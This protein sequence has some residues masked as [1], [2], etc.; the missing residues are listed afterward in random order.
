[1]SAGREVEVIIRD[2][3][4]GGAG[5][6]ELPDGRVAFVPFTLEG[7]RVRVRVT[8]EKKGFAE[9]ELVELREASPKRVRPICPLFGQCGGCAYQ[10]AD[11]AEQVRIK[12]KQVR[13][14]LERIGG[15]RDLPSP[16]VEPAPA[17]YGYRNKI[18]VHSA[19]SGAMGFYS[20]DGKSVVDVA[21][22]PIAAPEVN[23]QLHRLRRT[24]RRPRH[25]VIEDAAARAGAPGGSFHQVNTAM[26]ARL[27]A[28]AREEAPA[29]GASRLLD[30]YCGAGFFAFG[31]A[32]LFPEVCG[33]DRDAR[34]I[35]AATARGSREKRENLR[36]FA[37]PVEEK[38]AWFLDAA[39]APKTVA[40][41]DPP[42]EGLDP[43]GARA[44][45]AA[46]CPRVLYVS[47]NPSTL[48]RDLKRLA[49]PDGPY[50]LAA[51]A[52][53]DMFPQTASVEAGA[54]LDLR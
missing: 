4:F 18:A 35:S 10:H 31:L 53:F 26:A 8:R 20:A 16:R 29:A 42:R 45:A 51:L 46:R 36:F 19:P 2:V 52:V 25:A 32:D 24:G 27:L 43:A 11:Y 14:T 30:A 38:L 48:A 47:C 44:L 39:N 5:V 9:A 50:R 28:W 34:A 6:G 1:M 12:A 3:A 49:G 40:L 23:E 7:E 33:L 15:L 54:R 22:C 41:V 21:R 37:A 13:D 17:P